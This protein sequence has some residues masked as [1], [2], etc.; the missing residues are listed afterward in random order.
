MDHVRTKP[1]KPKPE[2]LSTSLRRVHPLFRKE[3][4]FD[5]G[6]VERNMCHNASSQKKPTSFVNKLK[7]FMRET[8]AKQTCAQ[9]Q[10]K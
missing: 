5:P 7:N 6:P 10:E 8:M 9:L 1:S 3:R 4:H 2:I